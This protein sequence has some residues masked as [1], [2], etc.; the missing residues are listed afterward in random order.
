[1]QMLAVSQNNFFQVIPCRFHRH[2]GNFKT[3]RCG[4]ISHA[5]LVKISGSFL[6]TSHSTRNRVTECYT[7]GHYPFSYFKNVCLGSGEVGNGK[8]RKVWKNRTW[9]QVFPY[10]LN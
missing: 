7:C 2:K 10:E 9:G 4:I 1:M 5:V 6:N 3:P 8:C